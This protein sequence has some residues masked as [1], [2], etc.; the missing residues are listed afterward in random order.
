MKL[1][2]PLQSYLIY[3]TSF[4]CDTKSKRKTDKSCLLIDEN[5]PENIEN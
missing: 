2:K 3:E 5:S 4:C 1:V